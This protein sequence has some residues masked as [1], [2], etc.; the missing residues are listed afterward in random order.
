MSIETTIN[1]IKIKKLTNEAVIPTQGTPDSVGWDLYADLSVEHEVTN[2][3]HYLPAI[4]ADNIPKT[5]VIAPH[6]TVK[7]ST[8]LSMEIPKGY[9]GALYSR[10]GLSTKKGLAP[11]NKVGVIDADYRGDIIIAL[12][13]DTDEFQS[14]QHHDRIGQFALEKINPLRFIEVNELDETER[15]HGGFASTGW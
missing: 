12:H 8:S 15:G 4:E 11:A 2:E 7:V 9:W 10:S 13:N 5:L 1:S 6:T 3:S 14:I